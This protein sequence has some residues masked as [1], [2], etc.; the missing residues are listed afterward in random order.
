[1]RRQ[2]VPSDAQAERAAEQRRHSPRQAAARDEVHGPRSASGVRGS[3]LLPSPRYEQGY[4]RSD[5]QMVHR[6][7]SSVDARGSGLM[8]F[9]DQR[10]S[11]TASSGRDDGVRSSP[12]M[13]MMRPPQAALS[14]RDAAGQRSVPNGV[15]SDRSYSE[16]QRSSSALDRQPQHSGMSRPS[17]ATHEQQLWE[18]RQHHRRMEE[19][20]ARLVQQRGQ[21]DSARIPGQDGYD[22]RRYELEERVRREQEQ[23]QPRPRPQSITPPSHSMHLDGPRQVRSSAPS[24]GWTERQKWEAAYAAKASQGR[25]VGVRPELPSP[26]SSAGVEPSYRRR[27]RSLDERHEDF[28]PSARRYLDEGKGMTNGESRYYPASS[29]ISAPYRD[30]QPAVNGARAP[31]E[32]TS[33]ASGTY[34]TEISYAVERRDGEPQRRYRDGN[35]ALSRAVQTEDQRHSAQDVGRSGIAQHDYSRQHPSAA[36]A[37]SSLPDRLQPHPPVIASQHTNMPP[38]A[39]P[40]SR[41]LKRLRSG[42]DTSLV[43]KNTR[44]TIEPGA[45]ESRRL[46]PPSSMLP[47]VAT[48]GRKHL[49][50]EQHHLGAERISPKARPF[51]TSPEKAGSLNGNGS[52]PITPPLSSN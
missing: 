36:L 4:L 10:S 35:G 8:S 41:P 1:M 47:P 22:C 45:G 46:S 5:G 3:E 7:A 43:L 49:P 42:S 23:S 19:E 24:Q 2:R 6:T 25:A 40:P 16:A 34:R 12:S 26:R 38:R 13:R 11:P 39:P 31:S 20:H 33:P 50:S 32:R 15:R 48:V 28:Y 52:A 14:D 29:Q 37:S 17:A 51:P 9:Q 44:F 21:S 27:E 30:Q 18:E